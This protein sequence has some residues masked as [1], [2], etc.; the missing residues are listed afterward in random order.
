MWRIILIGMLLVGVYTIKTHVFDLVDEV[1]DDGSALTVKNR[2]REDRIE[3]S[4]IKN[5]SYSPNWHPPW[6]TLSLR[7]PS[8]FGDRISFCAP[9]RF[10]PFPFATSS[11]IIDLIDRIEAAQRSDPKD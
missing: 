9:M 10:L 11:V 2:H 4:N 1:L 8:V 7:K 5:V 3:L 6:V